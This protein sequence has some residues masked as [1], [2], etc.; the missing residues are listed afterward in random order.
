MPPGHGDAQSD[1]RIGIRAIV[2]G[3][4]GAHRREYNDRV[5][6]ATV[7]F[8][9]LLASA[10]LRGDYLV[11]MRGG[12]SYRSVKNPALKNGTYVFTATDGTL[13][14]VRKADVTSIRAVP[15]ARPEMVPED[16]GVT[17]SLAGAAK[18]QRETARKIHEK[19]KTMPQ[20]NDAYR[21]GVG[22]PL[23]PGTNDYLVGKTWAPPAGSAVYTGDAP[24]GVPSGDAP[25]GAPSGPAPT[26]VM[27]GDA[28]KGEPP[29]PPPPPGF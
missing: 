24:K 20:K 16:L 15:I 10:P 19:P 13:L 23:M 17:S 28:P 27:S 8:A 3:E 12:V 6:I 5:K 18:N 1:G 4:G 29:P 9:L 26:G 7:L 14:S 22:V 21:P 11:S 2:S 25:A